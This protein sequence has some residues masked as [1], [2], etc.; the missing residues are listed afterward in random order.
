MA[1][2]K[3]VAFDTGNLDLT[4]ADAEVET[5]QWCGRR[6]SLD[7][8]FRNN[9]GLRGSI[10]VDSRDIV[11]NTGQVLAA[12]LAETVQLPADGD[13]IIHLI[14]DIDIDRRPDG[15]IVPA[16]RFI[17]LFVDGSK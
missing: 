3:Y 1:D 6:A 2:A 17:F 7:L 13:K 5:L 8:R 16:Q 15:L 4:A 11:E 9:G 10:A 12:D 14:R